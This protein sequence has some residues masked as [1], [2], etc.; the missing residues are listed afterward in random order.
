MY[1]MKNSL[2]QQQSSKSAIIYSWLVSRRWIMRAVHFS[3][4]TRI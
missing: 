4:D 2:W 3:S 1:F